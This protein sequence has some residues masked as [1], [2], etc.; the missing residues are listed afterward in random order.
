MS[1]KNR[2]W[3]ARARGKQG[4]PHSRG[5]HTAVSLERS[6][7]P[8]IKV[9]EVVGIVIDLWRMHKRAEKEEVSERFI[10][11]L[12]RSLERVYGL[13][14]EIRELSNEPYDPHMNVVVVENLG[15]EPLRIVEC[16]T[17]AVYYKGK[18]VER[19]NVVIG[20][21]GHDTTDR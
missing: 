15:G 20:G 12:E 8:Q 2:R 6:A 9:S 13:G 3:S 14:F 18:L 21:S 16:L 5:N 17:P 1:K 11:A 10:I 4:K 19:A 7:H